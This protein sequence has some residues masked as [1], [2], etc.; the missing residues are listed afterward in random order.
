MT[1]I[2]ER[3]VLDLTISEYK[4]YFTA[5][6]GRSDHFNAGKSPTA[7]KS[8]LLKCYQQ[9]H[10]SDGADSGRDAGGNH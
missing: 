6:D 4:E 3:V 10:Y 5:D 1:H 7:A 2:A 9:Q 8:A